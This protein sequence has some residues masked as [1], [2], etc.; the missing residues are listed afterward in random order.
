MQHSPNVHK[1]V[2]N[3]FYGE[4]RNFYK[5]EA[6]VT[7][8]GPVSYNGDVHGS[9]EQQP[10]GFTDEQI[11]RALENITGKGKALD[12]KQKWA[13]VLWLLRWTCNYPMKAQDFCERIAQLPFQRELE[14][15]CEYNNIRPLST[16]SFLN[17]DPRHMDEVRYS[18]NDEQVFFQLKEV[19]TA[20]ASELQK[21][22]CFE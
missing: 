3:N 13:G 20:L 21:V 19:A 17:C 16:L 10:N 5:C 8:N 18:K 12:S 9:K 14:F 22:G 1:K 7:F 15:K 4:I 11:A 2:V 6:P